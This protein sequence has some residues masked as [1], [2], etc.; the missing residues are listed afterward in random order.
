M[1]RDKLT[2]SQNLNSSYPY[3][4]K[5]VVITEPFFVNFALLVVHI[6]R[7]VLAKPCSHEYFDTKLKY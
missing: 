1:V 7:P 3:L 6:D 2:M 4:K 5:F